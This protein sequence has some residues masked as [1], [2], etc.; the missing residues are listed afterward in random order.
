MISLVLGYSKI[1]LLTYAYGKGGWVGL[2]LKI[3]Y[4]CLRAHGWVG[5]EFLNCLRMLTWGVGGFDRIPCLRNMWM[6]PKQL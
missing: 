6:T 3:A 5:F 4:G 1:W 2:N